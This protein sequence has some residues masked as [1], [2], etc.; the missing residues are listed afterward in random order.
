MSRTIT[1]ELGRNYEYQTG[2]GVS[3][4]NTVTLASPSGDQNLLCAK[5]EQGFYQAQV[6]MQEFNKKL[7]PEA[8]EA[9]VSKTTET[10]VDMPAEE[11]DVEI[12]AGMVHA[13]LMMSKTVDA[14]VYWDL[15]RE[16]V[17][18]KGVCHCGDSEVITQKLWNDLE[19]MDQ[20][21]MLTEYIAGFLLK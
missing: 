12:D 9:A 17:L 7:N 3:E 19:Y 20:R 11:P 5:L 2:G 13:I 18:K 14:A 8:F 21:K 15:F 16:V 6:E 4:F 10:E 1:V